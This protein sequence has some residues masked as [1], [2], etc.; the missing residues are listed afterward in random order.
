MDEAAIVNV[1]VDVE[2][3]GSV[4][5]SEVVMLFVAGPP[6]EP[7]ITGER[8]VKELKGFAKVELDAGSRKRVDIPLHVSDLR[9]WEGDAGGSWMLDPG[10]YTIL[11]APNADTGDDTLTQ[12][13]S[14]RP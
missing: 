5:G 9:H 6:K 12:T 1:S 3:T 14:V 8:P 4:A 13:L 7:G 10:D 11:V 2:N